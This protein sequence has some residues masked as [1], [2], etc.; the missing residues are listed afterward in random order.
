MSWRL[1]KS[2]WGDTDVELRESSSFAFGPPRVPSPVDRSTTPKPNAPAPSTKEASTPKPAQARGDD[3][4]QSDL[5]A[6]SVVTARGLS[7]PSGKV[8][9]EKSGDALQSKSL[10]ERQTFL[11]YVVLEFDK[12]EVLILASSGD[13][14][15]PQWQFTA[16]L[17][18]PW[19]TQ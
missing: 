9:A 6:V 17:Y 7:L 14:S 4:A 2:M 15:A 13:L 12:N 10:R 19:L 8:L 16:Y 5:L 11:P 18:V 1:G 3:A